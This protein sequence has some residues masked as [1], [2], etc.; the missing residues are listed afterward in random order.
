MKK[1]TDINDPYQTPHEAAAYMRTAT[2]TLAKHRL[3]GTGPA[4]CRVGRS[5]R[6]R[7]SDLDKYMESKLQRSTFETVQS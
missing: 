5:I 6:Y 2:S 4:F 7:T 3:Y 1:F